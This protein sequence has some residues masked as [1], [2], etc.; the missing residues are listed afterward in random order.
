MQQLIDSV[1]GLWELALLAWRTRFRFKG[2]YWR[3]RRETA[4]SA[5]ASSQPSRWQ[6]ARA[7]LEYGRW[8]YRIK[9]GR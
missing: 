9:R 5:N 2:S 1:G 4:F 8:L 3:W 6:R 7:I